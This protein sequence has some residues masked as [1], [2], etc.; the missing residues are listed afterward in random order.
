METRLDTLPAHW[1]R[2]CSNARRWVNCPGCLDYIRPEG[3]DGGGF[4]ADVGTL[5]HKL[6]ECTLTGVAIVLNKRDKEILNELDA[7]ERNWLKRSVAMCV[8]FVLEKIA[9]YEK[10][11]PGEVKVTFESKVVSK[12]VE[13]HG[14][15]V[16]VSIAT[17][18]ELD[19][20]DFKFGSEAVEADDNEQ[21]MSY[22]NLGRERHGDR[23][24]YFGT[25]V[26]PSYRGAQTFRYTCEQLDKFRVRMIAATKSKERHGDPSWCKYCP[27]LETCSAAAKMTVNAIDEFGTLIEFI[28]K[29]DGPTAEN[30]EALERVVMMHKLATDAY[31]DASKLLKQWYNDGAKLKYHRVSS[32]N[33]RNW[34]GNAYEAVSGDLNPDVLVEAIEIKL[35]TPAKLQKL[36]GISK[37]EFNTKYSAQL[38]LTSRPSLKCGAKPSPNELALDLPI[39][40]EGDG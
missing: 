5:G 8:G 19:V 35:T 20:T 11:N 22:I 39:Y 24:R 17:P 38:E 9:H 26:Q 10:K 13:K 29:S 15:T 23:Q 40:S 31:K 4:M 33:I 27:L 18:F 25:I 21:V 32:S 28:N 6:V 30:I 36:L 12:L 2:G 14:G 37:E 16:D 1:A 7:D 3:E 34:R